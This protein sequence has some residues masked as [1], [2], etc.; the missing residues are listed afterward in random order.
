M[1]AI[2]ESFSTETTSSPLIYSNDPSDSSDDSATTC[3]E[4]ANV[5][6]KRN[7]ATIQID[8]N[9]FF[10]I[11]P[12]YITPSRKLLFLVASGCPYL[13][14][15]STNFKSLPPFYILVEFPTIKMIPIS[16]VFLKNI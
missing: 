5:K 13:L 16:E 6:A 12:P 3:P 9:V 8:L 15:S 4:K 14:L 11:Y 1:D 7:R 2:S 10:T